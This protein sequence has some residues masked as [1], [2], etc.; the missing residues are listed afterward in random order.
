MKICVFGAGAIGGRLGAELAR[1][2]EDVTLIARGE[3]LRAMKANGVRLLLGNE[4]R[5][6]RP[7]CTDDPT[8]AGP[9][10]YVFITLKA[11]SVPAVADRMRPLFGPDTAV[12]TAANGVPW[13]YFYKLPGPWENRRIE[14]VDPAGRQWEAIG[15]ERAIGCVLYPAAEVVAPGVIRHI[16]GDRYSLGEPD[17]SRSERCLRLS[18]TLVAAGLKAPV[19]PRIREEIWVKLW[20]NLA[21]NPISALTGATLDRIARDPGTRAVARAMMLEGESVAERLGITL[22]ID[23]DARIKEAGAV[24]AHKTSMLQDLERGRPMELDPV[25][26]AVAEL[27]RLV[28]IPTPMIDAV[29]ALVRRR[30]VD[31]GCF[32]G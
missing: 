4:E 9:Q 6:V 8:E 7:L 1:A 22:P 26:G 28:G 5:V 12:V 3:H 15:P 14:S 2:G 11:H 27:G 18:R 20:G 31:A 24:G 30:A 17:G 21:F 19:R 29:Y 16:S 23:V 25:V 10:D 13:W 32:P